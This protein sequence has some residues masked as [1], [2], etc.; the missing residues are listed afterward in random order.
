MK[1]IVLA[2]GLWSNAAFCQEIG[3]GVLPFHGPKPDGPP[4]SYCG[5]GSGSGSGSGPFS[6]DFSNDFWHAWLAPSELRR[7]LLASRNE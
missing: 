7:V 5:I 3:C 2:F 1:W 4:F 6:T